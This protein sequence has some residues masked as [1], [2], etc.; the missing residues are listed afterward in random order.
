[1]QVL[2]RLPVPRMQGF[3]QRWMERGVKY[4]PLTG[5]IVGL[6]CGGVLLAASYLWHGMLP[7]ATVSSAGSM[8][9]QR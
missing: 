3:A 1:M 4:F 7:A 6:A 5:A 2:T 8:P 9:C